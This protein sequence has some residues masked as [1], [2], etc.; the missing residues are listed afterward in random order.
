MSHPNVSTRFL[1][2]ATAALCMLAGLPAS[3]QLAPVS[4]PVYAPNAA[5]PIVPR[6]GF[7]GESDVWLSMQLD[8]AYTAND[9]RPVPGEV[10]GRTYIRYL[11]SFTHPIPEQF[12][13]QS[14]LGGSAG[15]GGGGGGGASP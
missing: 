12:E 2:V 7:G 15:G 1:A 4:A 9:P 14:F 8:P 13:R 6:H 5:S 3:A 11:G 10:A